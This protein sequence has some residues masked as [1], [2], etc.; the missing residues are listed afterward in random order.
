MTAA[1]QRGRHQDSV[2]VEKATAVGSATTV[3]EPWEVRDARA[4]DVTAAAAAVAELLVE[5]GGRVPDQP[6][7]EVE[8][9][10][11]VEDPSVGIL[12]LAMAPSPAPPGSGASERRGLYGTANS[13]AG[14]SGSEA[15]RSSSEAGVGGE[16]VG[17]VVGVLA[18]SWGRAL[19]VPGRYLTIQDLWVRSE[20]RSAGV[21]AGLVEGL[22]DRAAAEGV[23][24]I[25]VGLP[26]ESFEA[27]RATE[28]F[29]LANGFEPLGPRLRRLL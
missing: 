10:A 5:L 6:A 25:E 17:K 9:R 7:L 3:S 26:R 29:Y 8:A 28:R 2:G 16:G 23:R 24:R 19:H 11:L 12:L 15:G 21:G 4:A 13:E 20:W 1:D 18:A 14:G 27:I 22:A